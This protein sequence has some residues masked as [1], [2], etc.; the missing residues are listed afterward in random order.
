MNQQGQWQT[1]QQNV[2]PQHMG[3]PGMDPNMTGNVGQ[4]GDD[5]MGMSTAPLS[6]NQKTSERMRQDEG[7]FNFKK[8]FESET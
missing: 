1:Q 5:G 8:T 6:Y 3:V 7:R 4:I 2:N